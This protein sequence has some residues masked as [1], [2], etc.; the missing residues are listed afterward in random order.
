MS[1][2]FSC[3]SENFS[4]NCEWVDI[5]ELASANTSS[6]FNATFI[7][8]ETFWSYITL[9]A[10]YWATAFVIRQILNQVQFRR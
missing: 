3:P 10:V 9:V 5:N 4:S 1:Y 6:F 2:I 8:S 7:D